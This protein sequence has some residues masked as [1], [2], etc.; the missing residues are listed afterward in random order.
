MAFAIAVV[1][2]GKS[3]PTSAK[4][5]FGPGKPDMVN[6]AKGGCKDLP[7]VIRALFEACCPY[8][9]RNNALWALNELANTPK[10]KI[11]VPLAIGG[12]AIGVTFR[13]FVPGRPVTITSSMRIGPSKWDRDKNEIVFLAIGPDSE[14]AGYDANVSYTVAFDDIDDLIKGQH[15]VAVLNAMA[16]E[17]ERILR[18]TEAECRRI[19]LIT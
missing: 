3:N 11:L 2:T 18:A 12:G 10:H 14:I 9:G 8:K 7:P 19:G 13:G 4:F 16:S 15:P 1:H 17:V 5:P 6:N